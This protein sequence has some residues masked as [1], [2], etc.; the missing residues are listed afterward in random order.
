M[1]SNMSNLKG[2]IW[3]RSLDLSAFLATTMINGMGVEN[4]PM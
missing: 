4:I 2:K 1:Q 3:V